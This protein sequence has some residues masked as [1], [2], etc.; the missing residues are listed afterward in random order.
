MAV[1]D[2]FGRRLTFAYSKGRLS[3]VTDPIG[4]VYTY[5]YDS[6]GNLTKVI[7]PDGAVR[8]YI[9]DEAANGVGST[10]HGYLTGVIDE[11]GSRLSSFWYYS[12]GVSRSQQAGGVD[13]WSFSFGFPTDP[14]T[15]DPNGLKRT[16]RFAMIAVRIARPESRCR[17][18]NAA[19][20][21][22]PF[23]MMRM[24]TSP[25][26]SDFNWVCRLRRTYGLARNLETVRWWKA[27]AGCPA[28]TTY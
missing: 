2:P 3:S 8:T 1:S 17:V 11:N 22:H 24:A 26:S 25:R 15:L 23:H 21:L 16:H 14:W 13:A 6:M 4:N 20:Y 5:S 7:W 27:S 28:N 9:Y 12:Y 19:R 10:M 18:R